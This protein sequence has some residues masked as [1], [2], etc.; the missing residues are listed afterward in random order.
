MPGNIA[1]TSRARSA[2]AIA[3]RRVPHAR[4][5]A[6]PVARRAATAIAS[7]A[8]QHAWTSTSA[9]RRPAFAAIRPYRS[10]TTDPAPTGVNVSDTATTT[11]TARISKPRFLFFFFFSLLI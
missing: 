2:A 10:A 1:T 4:A 5:R 7:T 3:M 6:P 9:R 11:T 8:R